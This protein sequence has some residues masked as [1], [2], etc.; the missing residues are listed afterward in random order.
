[1]LVK[2]LLIWISILEIAL[3]YWLL[4]G[5]GL[6]IKTFRKKEWGIIFINMISMGVIAGIN[7]SMLFFSD[8]MFMINVV[9]TCVC[10][11]LIDKQ[12]IL[13]KAIIVILY[14]TSVALLDFFFAFL[15]MMVLEHEFEGRVYI[16]ANSMM[17]FIIFI[18]SRGAIA[19]IVSL[20]VKKRYEKVYIYEFRRILLII[21]ILM[22]VML[23]RYQIIIVKL[24]SEGR[25][26]EARE[27]GISLAG[28]LLFIFFIWM[29][30]MK[31]R[32]LEKEKEILAMR[33][34]MITRRFAEQ[35]STM[36][37]IRQL[38]HDLKNHFIVLKNY[39]KEGN[40]EGIHN[41]IEEI[42]DEFFVVKIRT[43]TG[44][45]IADMLLEQKRVLAEQEG[46]LFTIQAVPIS[47]WILN[48]SETCSLLSNLL[49]NAIEACKRMEHNEDKWIAIKI[50]NQKQ[51]LFIK[52][53][54]AVNEAP[55]IKNGKLSSVKHDKEKHGYGLKSVERIVSKYEGVITY[56]SKERVFQ[57][58]I[59]L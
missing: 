27:A 36:E 52:V 53:E 59:L 13:L 31:N 2:A 43:W 9:V 6:E 41:Y 21:S 15:S 58:K 32:M 16:Y 39:A 24:M 56:H 20:I 22:C 47:E 48:D 46:V 8:N 37:K 18:C 49:D 42:E 7:R 26:Q 12:N 19:A 3:L 4:C 25:E 29:L 45:H 33:D 54:N 51:L 10:T 38:S 5:T 55:I 34:D 17:E 14:D 50:E 30:Y 11:I 40:C 57:V 1:M 23:R 44:N 28:I 35:E